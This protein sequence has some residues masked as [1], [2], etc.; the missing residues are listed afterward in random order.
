MQDFT[1]ARPRIFE[2]LDF[3]VFL[4]ACYAS[5]KQENRSFSYRYYAGKLGVDSG[6]F[7]R[8]MNGE[9]NL[10]PDMAG[11]LARI[12]GLN[13]QEREYFEALVL[14]G[15][16]KSLSEK[17]PFLERV[18]RL[19]G[20]RAN[21]LEERQFA[22]YREWF[23]LAIRELLHFYPFDGN[24]KKLAKMVR[25]AI[26]TV[27]A[28]RTIRLLLDIGLVKLDDTGRLSLT[29]TLITSG[30]SI[31]AVFLNNL[32]LSMAELAHRALPQVD[33]V[34]RDFSGLTFSL[35]PQG[36]AKVKDRTREFRRELLEIAQHDKDVEC[37]Y[38]MNLQLFP[39]SN[40]HK[41]ENP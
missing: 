39:V 31:R 37:V 32:H 17:T 38:R 18:F 25:P 10:D 5:R 3:R 41:P 1:I 34:E 23:H 29:D 24:Y 27:E 19:R 21:P 15:Q 16:A 36:F 35:S 28:K 26:R 12:F 22:F 13:D 9:R 2:F 6:T 8:I 40:P 33:P 20:S 7:S 11:K 14:F 4:R 30:D